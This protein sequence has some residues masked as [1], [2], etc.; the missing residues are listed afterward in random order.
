METDPARK[1]GTL[2]D[3][4]NLIKASNKAH[5]AGE[6][7]ESLR[8]RAEADH[9]WHPLRIHRA[10]LRYMTKQFVA[11]FW[12]QWR[13]VSGLPVVPTYHEAK[14]GHVHHGPQAAE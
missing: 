14:M 10:S 5:A 3:K 6:E 7:E 12:R 11:D 8:L 1:K 13:I 4:K 2:L 9:L